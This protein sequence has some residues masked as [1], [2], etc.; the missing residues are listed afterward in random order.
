LCLN[1][2]LKIDAFNCFKY[3]KHISSSFKGIQ[4]EVPGFSSAYFEVRDFDEIA[5]KHAIQRL[6]TPEE[7]TQGVMWLCS[8][9]A[10]FAIGLNL[11]LDGGYTLQ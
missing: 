5:R 9:G 3:F 4:I 1:I 8:D 7:I 11:L 6:A 10:S 2:S